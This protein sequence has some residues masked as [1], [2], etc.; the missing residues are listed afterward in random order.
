MEITAH[1][2][3]QR[4]PFIGREREIAEIA[5]LLVQPACRLLTLVGPGGIGKTRLA[6]EV[7]KH[8]AESGESSDGIYFVDFQPLDTSDQLVTTLATA[9]GMKFYGEQHPRLQLLAYLRNRKLILVIDNFEHLLNE[10]DLL[11]EILSSGAG[12]KLLV[13]SR[14]ALNVQEEWLWQVVGLQVPWDGNITD[15][16]AYS[17]VRL[18]VERVRRIRADFALAGHEKDVQLICQLVDGMPLALELAASWSRALACA[19]IANEIQK[20]LDFL[21]TSVRNTPARHQSMRAVFERSWHRL[22][23][24]QRTV[25]PG[26]SVFRGGFRR[27][28]A[29]FVAGA[30]LH[31]LAELADKS[32]LRVS[33]SGRY[34]LHELMRQYGEE[35]LDDQPDNALRIRE[36]HSLFYSDFMLE[37]RDDLLGNRQ[38]EGMERIESEI[39]NVRSAFARSAQQG[40]LDNI[41][42]SFESLWHFYEIYDLD[43]EG[44]EVFGKA[45]EAIEPIVYSSPR[46]QRT[47]EVDENQQRVFGFVL[48]GYAGCM[49]HRSRG[50]EAKPLLEKA[51]AILREISPNREIVYTLNILIQVADD[52]AEAEKLTY[53]ALAIARQFDFKLWIA[54]GLHNLSTHT[55]RQGYY[56]R[57]RQLAEEVITLCREMNNKYGEVGGLTNLCR[58][59]CYEGNY[60]EARYLA[61]QSRVMAQTIKMQGTVAWCD[62]LLGNIAYLQGDFEGA[63]TAYLTC[64]SAMEPSIADYRVADCLSDLGSCYCKLLDYREARN[65]FLKAFVIAHELKNVALFMI[66]FAQVT[67]LL[68]Q[69]GQYALGLE[70]CQVVYD[71]P[72]SEYHFRQQVLALRPAFEAKF[73]HAMPQT[74]EAPDPHVLARK[75]VD[76]L[77][78]LTFAAEA[79]GTNALTEDFSTSQPNANVGTS[80]RVPLSERELDVLRLLEQGLSNPEI[81]ERLVISAGTV[82][83]HARNIYDKL[84]VSNRTQAVVRAHELGLI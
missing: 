74:T 27:E 14:E 26:L 34:D 49:V 35:R 4:T 45:V 42:K 32:F 57:S 50:K 62:Q 41:D 17:A 13:T 33:A 51:L 78:L 43:H 25:F 36:L 64:L 16:D 53:E 39:D 22:T 70:L 29:A 81:A 1:L 69:A 54:Q 68:L 56:V 72:L 75:V 44:V 46:S 6:I 12:I 59:A 73:P 52:Y 82:K 5:A 77:E 11:V 18:F 47:K 48:T 8:I 66:V 3:S 28:A 65:C 19:E 7:A 80:L 40:H 30:S 2:P 63:K 38:K 24:E 21:T 61:Q 55:I 83:V 15:I 71:H 76:V 58:V 20:G 10:V 37:C 79:D 23:D 84:D 9:I 31:T 67:E 60:Q